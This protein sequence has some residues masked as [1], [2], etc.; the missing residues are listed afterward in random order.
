MDSILNVETF[1]TRVSEIVLENKKAVG[2]IA[3]GEKDKANKILYKAK[4][5][6]ALLCLFCCKKYALLL[7]YWTFYTRYFKTLFYLFKIEKIIIV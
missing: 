1:H 5:K 6:C 2:L 4:K 7:R 3:N